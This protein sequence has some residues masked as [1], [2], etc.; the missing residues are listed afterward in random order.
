MAIIE[1]DI[2]K[3]SLPRH[4]TAISALTNPSM[5][6]AVLDIAVSE[7]LYPPVIV[8]CFQVFTSFT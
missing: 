3:N 8:K 6:P 4:I 1:I 2:H 7:L 5:D